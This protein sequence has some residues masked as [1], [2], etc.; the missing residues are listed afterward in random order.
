MHLPPPPPPPARFASTAYNLGFALHSNGY[1]TDAVVALELCT[2]QLLVWLTDCRGTEESAL[3]T[4]NEVLYM[5]MY[6]HV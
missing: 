4:S 1:F 6:M 5:Y 3:L 2:D